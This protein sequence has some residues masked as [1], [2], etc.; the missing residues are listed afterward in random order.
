MF[1]CLANIATIPRYS[2]RADA[3][4]GQLAEPQ[5]DSLYGKC[6]D[7]L[8]QDADFPKEQLCSDLVNGTNILSLPPQ[9]KQSLLCDLI[10]RAYPEG[11]ETIPECMPSPS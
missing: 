7:I 5:S 11:N 6:L 9:E 3:Q 8:G 2:Y 10:G 1:T 4:V